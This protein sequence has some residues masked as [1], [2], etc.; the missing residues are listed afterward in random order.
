M[1]HLLRMLVCALLM[2]ALCAFAQAEETEPETFT[3]GDYEYILLEDGTAE[4]TRFNGEQTHIRLPDALDGHTVSSLAEN[5]I[6]WSARATSVIIPNSM[7]K[8][9]ENYAVD[10]IVFLPD[11]P[12][13]ARID[14]VMFSK[15]DKRLISAASGI[16]GT[17]YRVPDGIK[18]IG[19]SAFEDAE[20]LAAVI[21][22]ESLTAIENNAF[23][24]CFSLKTVTIPGNVTVIGDGAFY[25]CNNLRTADIGGSVETI[26]RYA[27]YRCESL[28]EVTLPGTVT[29]IGEGAFGECTCLTRITIPASV[30][31]IG[32]NAFDYCDNLTV[33]VARGSYAEQY[34]IENGLYFMY[35]D[36]LDWLKQ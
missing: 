17:T 8:V 29:A 2:A 20:N 14:G 23:N 16:I 36:S 33:T 18:I 25:A 19:E 26:G 11:H 24:C 35:P 22:P 1:K 30:T 6:P 5:A 9:A 28:A 27:F 4:I 10:R 21:L 12:V 3:S 7:T 34:C 13:L 31:A 32:E 15:P